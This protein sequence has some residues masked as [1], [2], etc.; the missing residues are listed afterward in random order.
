MDDDLRRVSAAM[1]AA[2]PALSLFIDDMV[3]IGC[4]LIIYMCDGQLCSRAAH[5]YSVL[6]DQSTTTEGSTNDIE[7]HPKE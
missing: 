2:A 3:W 1:G 5:M 7:L 6:N 4:G